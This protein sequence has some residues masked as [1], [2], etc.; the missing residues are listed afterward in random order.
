MDSYI[1]KQLLV[2]IFTISFGIYGVYSIY[3]G[4]KDLKKEDNIH[5]TRSV[6]YG[7]GFVITSIIGMIYTISRIISFND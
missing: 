2:L 5:A 6:I 1:L 3:D 4:K 7:I